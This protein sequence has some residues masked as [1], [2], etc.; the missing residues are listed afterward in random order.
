MAIDILG[1]VMRQQL[2]SS[3]I[4]NAVSEQKPQPTAHSSSAHHDTF[5]LFP[6][7]VKVGQNKIIIILVEHLM[8]DDWIKIKIEMS[9]ETIEITNVKRRNPYTIQFNIPGLIKFVNI[10]YKSQLIKLLKL[11]MPVWKFP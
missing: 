7:K 6:R 11:Q 5:T 3:E 8:K 9:N 10:L 1:R 2:L 4:G